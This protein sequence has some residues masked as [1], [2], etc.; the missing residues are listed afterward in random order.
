VATGSPFED[1]DYGGKTYAI[2][3]GNNAFIFPGLGFGSMLSEASQITDGMVLESAYALADYTAA[4]HV[5]AGRVYPP[6]RE[7]QEVS[8]R[9]ATRVI[10]RAIA[11]GVARQGG[12]DSCD[13]DTYV[14]QRFWRPRHL[15]MVRGQTK[16]DS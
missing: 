13:L 11:E 1:V 6:I 10:A 14:R 3:Q 7:L 2:G 15:P 9:V 12:L 8:I 5:E 4:K 16:E